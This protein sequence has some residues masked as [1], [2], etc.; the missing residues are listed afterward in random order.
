VTGGL[1]PLDVAVG[2]LLPALRFGPVTREML[3]RYAAA[4]LDFNPIHIDSDFAHA[5]G[6]DDV[7]AHGMLSFGLAARLVAEWA[8]AGRVRR[9]AGK[10]TAITH[11]GDEIVVSGRVCAIDTGDT[12]RRVRVELSAETAGTKTVVAEALVSLPLSA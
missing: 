12:G 1:P 11:V 7:I 4:S 5:A 6:R 8:G 9:I 2:D 3:A 10:F